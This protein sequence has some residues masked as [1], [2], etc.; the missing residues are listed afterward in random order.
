[1]NRKN[2][3]DCNVFVKIFTRA[4]VR[5]TLKVVVGYSCDVTTKNFIIPYFHLGIA[6]QHDATLSA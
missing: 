5:A 2:L 4:A 6:V 3:N 1:M